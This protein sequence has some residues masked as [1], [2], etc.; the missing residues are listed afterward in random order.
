MK[1]S[2][3]IVPHVTPLTPDEQLDR[4]GLARLI[5]FLLA[6]GVHGLF[7]NGSMG[8]FALLP[9]AQQ[10]ETVAESVAL[11]GGR[12]PVLAGVSDTSTA[13]VLARIRHVLPLGPDAI[14]ALPPFYYWCRQDE[15]ARFYL[16]IADASTR[17]VVLYDN[18]KLV[19]NA[20][21]PETIAKLAAHPNICGV[22]VS[23]PDAFK[24]QQVLRQE[25]PRDRVG[26]VCGAEHMMSLA[27]QLGFDG[28]AGG[29]HNLI[30]GLAVAL[31]E[32]GRAGRIEEAERL[33]QKLNRVLRVFEIDGGWRGAQVALSALGICDKVAASP[34]DLPLTQ[35]KHAEILEILVR[36][37][38]LDRTSPAIMEVR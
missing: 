13:R 14:V 23:A 3:V 6:A 21:A 28:I 29:L 31:F 10:L 34:H 15:I 4:E 25:L 8:G 27:L 30:P 9:D 11:V 37:G 16:A 22:K 35:K 2:G 1:L 20:I 36:E 24:W 38:V 18:P 17:P 26:L 12:V 7:V 33:Q 19:R 5:E 32:A